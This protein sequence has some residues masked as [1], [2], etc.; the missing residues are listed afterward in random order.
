MENPN[1]KHLIVYMYSS[2]TCVLHIFKSKLLPCFV[3]KIK[4]I[5]DILYLSIVIMKSKTKKYPAS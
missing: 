1:V 3:M 5:K 2:Q 4:P